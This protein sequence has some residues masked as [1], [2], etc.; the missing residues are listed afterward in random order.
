MKA[1]QKRLTDAELEDV[2]HE[3]QVIAPVRTIGMSLAD[4]KNN[5]NRLNAEDI[6]AMTGYLFALYRHADCAYEPHARSSDQEFIN[7]D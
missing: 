7:R 5:V 1:T 2:I 3:L 6:S 4:F